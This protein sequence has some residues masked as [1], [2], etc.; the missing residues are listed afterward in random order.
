MGLVEQQARHDKETS[1]L[2]AIK[3]K[4]TALMVIV[5]G[6]LKISQIAINK[7]TNTETKTIVQS[8]RQ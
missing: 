2:K 7:K 4:F 6:W 5:T 1:L 3:S 8:T